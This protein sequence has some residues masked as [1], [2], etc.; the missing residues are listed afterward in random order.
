MRRPHNPS[1]PGRILWSVAEVA[2]VLDWH[3]HRVRRWLVREKACTRH[4]RHYY[5][6]KNQLRRVFC[7]AAD[8]IIAQLPE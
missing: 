6:S 8:E 2:E 1:G 3:T 4:G 7:E 5:T